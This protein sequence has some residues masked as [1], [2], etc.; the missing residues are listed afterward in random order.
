MSVLPVIFK[1]GKLISA[2]S[3]PSM[4]KKGCL[5]V[6]KAVINYAEMA[7]KLENLVNLRDYGTL[8]Q[9]EIEK[10]QKW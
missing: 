9:I 8:M 6:P 10:L 4:Q 1:G 3:F 7:A 5:L 2:L